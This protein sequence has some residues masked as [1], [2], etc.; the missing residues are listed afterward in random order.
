MCVSKGKVLVYENKQDSFVMEFIPESVASTMPPF[1]FSVWLEAL[2]SSTMVHFPETCLPQFFNPFS[3]TSSICLR[4]PV[5][6]LQRTENR[7]Y[8]FSPVIFSPDLFSQYFPLSSLPSLSAS[9]KGDRALSL[10]F[11]RVKN[12]RVKKCRVKIAMRTPHLVSKQLFKPILHFSH[13]PT[14]IQKSVDI[15][16]SLNLILRK[17][18]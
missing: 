8:L 2:T 5:C 12:I 7:K 3:F 10:P 16:P 11:K 4:R 14:Y 13:I 9:L 6:M 1:L 18:N 15:D 17:K